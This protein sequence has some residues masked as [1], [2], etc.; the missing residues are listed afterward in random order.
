M[1]VGCQNNTLLMPISPTR[2]DLKCFDALFEGLLPSWLKVG[3]S[4]VFNLAHADEMSAISLQIRFLK[5]STRV[6]RV[7]V[8]F[9]NSS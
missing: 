8:C 6:S 7:G 4:G 2:I 5:S 1:S 3:P 9:G